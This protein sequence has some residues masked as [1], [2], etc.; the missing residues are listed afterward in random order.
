MTAWKVALI[1]A[2]T[3]VAVILVLS[4]VAMLV[5]HGFGV[6]DH[7]FGSSLMHAHRMRG[8]AFSGHG[9]RMCAHLDEASVDA[10]A[11]VA[12]LWIDRRLDLDDSQA[13]ALAPM[14]DAGR[15]LAREL[16]PLCEAPH[17]DAK[18]AVALAADAAEAT[19]GAVQRIDERF[20]A[21][22]D[23]LDESQRREVDALVLRHHGRAQ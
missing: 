20:A 9:H 4:A 6:G 11:E 23:A 12:T 14:I 21:F 1:S 5:R 7:G 10:F 19:N 16:E 8:A 18:A 3:T 15:D 13:E 17:D 22:Y 2:A